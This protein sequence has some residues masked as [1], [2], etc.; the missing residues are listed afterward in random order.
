MRLGIRL[1]GPNRAS[2]EPAVQRGSLQGQLIPMA[3]RRGPSPVQQPLAP[4]TATVA[5]VGKKPST[6]AP[7]VFR[8]TPKAQL[9]PGPVDV[10]PRC[11]RGRVV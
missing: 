5:V 8:L 10:K 9:A 3:R 1:R 6:A 11:Q 4:V 7:G 2:S